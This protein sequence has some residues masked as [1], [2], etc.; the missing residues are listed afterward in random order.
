MKGDC[1][2]G[3]TGEVLGGTFFSRQAGKVV[4]TSWPGCPCYRNSF[5]GEEGKAENVFGRENLNQRI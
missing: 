2:G 1:S 4:P 3:R 5:L